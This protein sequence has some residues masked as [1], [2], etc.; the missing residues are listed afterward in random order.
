MTGE[1]VQLDDFRKP[2]P[3]DEITTDEK[4]Q[5]AIDIVADKWAG[6]LVSELI[7]SFTE[8]SDDI[9]FTDPAYTKLMDGILMVTRS[10]TRHH[11]GVFDE[12]ALTLAKF[13]AGEI[14]VGVMVRDEKKN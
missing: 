12:V 2:K 3:T 7:A 6:E 4:T 11:L 9:D 10:M 1:V 13:P 14:S 5:F 8:R